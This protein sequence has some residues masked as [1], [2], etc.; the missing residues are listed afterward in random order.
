MRPFLLSMVLVALSVPAFAADADKGKTLFQ[1][2]CA[3]C[4]Q[5]AQP[6]N[7]VGPHLQGVVGRAAAS[8]QGFG[9]SPALK[10]AG[11]QWTPDQLDAYLANPTGKVPGTRMAVRV[12]G[13]ADRADII[14]FLQG[15]PAP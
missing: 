11:I 5:V 14:A 12:A 13:E 1:R 9:Y 8:A 2:Q 3:V 15:S 6:R 10:G 7:G 4:H